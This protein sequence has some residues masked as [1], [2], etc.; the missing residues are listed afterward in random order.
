MKKQRQETTCYMT[1]GIKYKA[2]DHSEEIQNAL[3]QF[4]SG[5]FGSGSQVPKNELIK[6]FGSYELSFGTIW[7][8]SYNL[9]RSREFITLLLPEEYEERGERT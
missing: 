2:L 1:E 3:E 9:F 4:K 7:I 8:I 6:H 5:A